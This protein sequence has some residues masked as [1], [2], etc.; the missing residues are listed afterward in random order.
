LE[1]LTEDR[2]REYEKH[3]KDFRYKRG[4]KGIT[5]PLTVDTQA[6]R[7]RT[8]K[9]FMGW[10]VKE[11]IIRQRPCAIEI[12]AG[13]KDA[14]TDLA[15]KTPAF[16]EAIADRSKVI[17]HLIMYGG[18]RVNNALGLQLEWVRHDVG[19]VHFPGTVMKNKDGLLLFLPAK[20]MAMIPA[21]GKGPAFPDMD[22]DMLR[23]D[24][25]MAAKK[26]GHKGR[27][28]I[29][30]GRV[31]SA[32]AVWRTEKDVKLLKERFGWRDDRTALHYVKVTE[33]Q[34]RAAAERIDFGGGE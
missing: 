10:M 28:R 12:P 29:H 17:A 30:D 27:F 25:Q 15:G 34:H 33:A 9:S 2:I 26:I 8:A 22:V 24:W 14:G 5:R 21:G 6:I 23:H 32:S 13:R 20:V 7:L 18:V 19:A 4:P 31:T 16:L 1:D 11:K 3:L